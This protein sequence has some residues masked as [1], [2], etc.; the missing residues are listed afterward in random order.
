MGE[1]VRGSPGHEARV[2]DG[3]LSANCAEARDLALEASPLYGPL[4][5]LAREGFTGTL[6]ELHARLDSMVS[7]AMRRSVRR[8]KT[9]RASVIRLGAWSPISAP[10]EWSF[11][12]AVMI[13]RQARGL[14][15]S[16]LRGKTPCCQ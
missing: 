13:C 5:E 8:P 4:A 15:A 12:S 2:S 16:L 7:D 14:R 10:P 1:R 6:A 11:S 9:P 3:S